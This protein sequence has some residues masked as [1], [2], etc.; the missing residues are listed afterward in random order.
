MPTRT[1]PETPRYDAT[2]QRSV[3]NVYDRDPVL[4]PQLFADVTP[5]WYR[6]WWGIVLGILGILFLAGLAFALE[7]Y[8]FGGTVQRVGRVLALVMRTFAR[9]VG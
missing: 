3:K 2:V 7:R 5:R 1:A 9:L 8:G 6:Q 4:I